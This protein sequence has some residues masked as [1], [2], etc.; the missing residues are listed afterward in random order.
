MNED[1]F[2][3]FFIFNNNLKFK[4]IKYEKGLNLKQH[5]S[6]KSYHFKELNTQQDILNNLYK[7]KNKNLKKKDYD[8]E[9]P[10][11]IK[12]VTET[13]ARGVSQYIN[14][15]YDVKVSNGYIKLWEIYNSIPYLVKNKKKLNVFHL[16]EAPGQWINCTQHYID[17]KRKNIKYYNWLAQSLNHKHPENIKKYGKGIFSDDY[18][19]LKK[20]PKK[21][22]YGEDDTGNIIKIENI[23][24]YKE[25]TK[26]IQLDLITGDAGMTGEN[27]KLEDL[28]KLE[29]AQL[30]MV[31][32]LS[33]KGTNCVIKHFLHFINEFKE[34]YH[35]SG[36]F[37]SLIYLYYIHFREVQL[38]KP[39]TSSPNSGEF[40]LVGIDF[41]GIDKKKLE[42]L[43]N[44]LEH[45]KINDCWIKKEDLPEEFIFQMMEF[46]KYIFKTKQNQFNKQLFLIDC[47]D[48]NKKSSK[49]KSKK[50]SS[51]SSKSSKKNNLCKKYLNMRFIRELQ[52]KRF[53][54][55]IKEY[56]FM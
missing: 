8:Y 36:Y 45:F 25:N 54:E 14:Y 6:I 51:K 44:K 33:K 31:L 19:L 10:L 7:E 41:Q 17:T 39:H 12:K 4:L 47:L 49:K 42:Y 52:T 5:K 37:F 48:V 20:N 11:L 23:K 32:S 53:R 43:Y 15:N 18:G 22:L 34:S 24:W 3:D 40:Y 21:W 26:D 55:W 56:R 27:I 13:Y 28:Q 35:G 46:I 16:A 30:L 9:L 2:Y 50:K 1:I 29:L 38:I